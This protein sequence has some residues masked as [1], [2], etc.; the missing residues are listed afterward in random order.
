MSCGLCVASSL[1]IGSMAMAFSKRDA[2]IAYELGK[3][4]ISLNKLPECYNLHT[5]YKINAMLNL[6]REPFHHRLFC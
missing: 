4:A 5:T 2:T 3:I 1:G 6:W